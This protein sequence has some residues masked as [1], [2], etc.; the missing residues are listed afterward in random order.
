[1][2][3][4]FDALAELRQ[5]HIGLLW[6]E[7]RSAYPIIEDRPAVE[8]VFEA[9]EEAIRPAFRLEISTSAPVLR[10]IF[11]SEDK[12]RLIQVQADRF[13][14]NWRSVGDPYP[15]YEELAAQ[16][17]ERF[18]AFADFVER[19][20]IGVIRP[21]Q[22]ELTY[23]NEIE[24]AQMGDFLRPVGSLSVDAPGVGPQPVDARCGAR[25]LVADDADDAGPIGALH[26]AAD[27]ARPGSSEGGPLAWQLR[28]TFRAPVAD[29]AIA[30]AR[31]RLAR[32]RS[33]IVET[34]TRLTTPDMHKRWERTQ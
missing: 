15:H 13:V 17:D 12:Q 1:M 27:L 8:P 34:F 19:E 11:L 23:V 9:L 22:V 14:H 7:L 31:H 20:Q 29:G 32:G 21:A 26:V 28:L 30:T 6:S 16:Y 18:R 33:A 10:A 24:A 5:A 4:Q 3:I 25:F 2:A